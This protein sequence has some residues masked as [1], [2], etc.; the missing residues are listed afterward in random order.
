MSKTKKVKHSRKEE[1][2]ARKVMK[3]LF[4]SMILL[5]LAMIIGFSLFG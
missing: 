3:I 1:Q 4:V 5:G 2:Q